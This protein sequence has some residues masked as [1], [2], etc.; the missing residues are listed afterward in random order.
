MKY[1]HIPLRMSLFVSK[2]L[3]WR[4]NKGNTVVRG[5]WVNRGSGNGLEI[6]YEYIFY[7]DTKMSLPWLKS[8]A[9]VTICWQRC[10]S[11][12]KRICIKWRFE[13]E[14]DIDYD[15]TNI[16]IW[17]CYY[18]KMIVPNSNVKWLI[19]KNMIVYRGCWFSFGC[20]LTEMSAYENVKIQV[21]YGS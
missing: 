12:H 13:M 19:D 18:W 14:P 6:P 16:E 17:Y 8:N 9:L 7:G 5:E 11:S 21:S 1:F 10:N 20:P 2:F 4:T 15:E 3:K